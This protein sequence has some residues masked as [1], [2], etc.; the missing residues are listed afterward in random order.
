MLSGLSRCFWQCPA[1][2]GPLRPGASSQ[3][4]S[5]R[6]RAAWECNP[7]T[8]ENSAESPECQWPSQL[9]AVSLKKV[10]GLGK[11]PLKSPALLCLV[12]Q[13]CPTRWDPMDCSSSGSSDHGDSPGKNTAVGCH[14]LLQGIVPT[15]RS[16]RSPT[17][18]ENYLHSEP[19]GKPTNT[20][21]SSLSLLQGIF[22]TQ[23]SNWGLLHCR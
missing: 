3:M 10:P 16:P 6:Y 14:A 18:Q 5:S 15:Q 7:K 13:S 22:P 23:E 19:P 17:L 11:G 12:A 9:G 20:G 8:Q 4:E 2:E 1:G 21:V